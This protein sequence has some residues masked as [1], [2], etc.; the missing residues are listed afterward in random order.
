[1]R[2]FFWGRAGKQGASVAAM[3]LTRSVMH[4]GALR[5]PRAHP[6]VVEAVDLNDLH[7]YLRL[8]EVMAT[9]EA[10]IPAGLGNW[11]LGRLNVAPNLVEIR[12]DATEGCQ[13]HQPS[14]PVNRH[15]SSICSQ[16]DDPRGIVL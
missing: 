2:R 6:V 3:P 8:V 14:A 11:T 12:V 1:M 15:H 7:Y 16:M 5:F 13:T 10:S 4:W 9:P